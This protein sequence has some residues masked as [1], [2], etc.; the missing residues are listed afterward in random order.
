MDGAA[1]DDGDEERASA[2]A[3]LMLFERSASAG[4][5]GP[6]ADGPFSATEGLERSWE[7]SDRLA[8]A[9]SAPTTDWST[10]VAL[11]DQ[12]RV[13][14]RA[15]LQHG[16]DD[17]RG[18]LGGWRSTPGVPPPAR[19]AAGRPSPTSGDQQRLP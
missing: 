3:V 10:V 12:L 18:D 16:A 11:A 2:T 13:L 6:H 4:D 15:G 19:V 1:G 7:L 14:A 9:L 8:H 17:G 5:H